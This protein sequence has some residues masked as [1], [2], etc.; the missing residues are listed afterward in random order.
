MFLHQELQT[1][2]R[3]LFSVD[4]LEKTLDVKSMCTGR[5]SLSFICTDGH[6]SH[7]DDKETTSTD[8]YAKLFTCLLSIAK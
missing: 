5:K 6:K 8:E 2:W 3:E 7:D 1:G 4:K